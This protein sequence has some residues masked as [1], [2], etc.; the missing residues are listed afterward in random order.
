MV[1]FRKLQMGGWLLA[2]YWLELRLQLP[3]RS[4]LVLE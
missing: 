1:H 4:V 3:M 2:L